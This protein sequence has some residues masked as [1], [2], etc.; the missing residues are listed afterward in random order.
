MNVALESNVGHLKD[1]KSK[2]ELH[3]QKSLKNSP[4]LID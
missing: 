2:K 1:R 3:L 4:E